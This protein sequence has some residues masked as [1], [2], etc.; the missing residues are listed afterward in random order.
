M[1]NPLIHRFLQLAELAF[2][3]MLVG[4]IM[5]IAGAVSARSVANGTGN[6]PRI[7]RPEEGKAAPLGIIRIPYGVSYKLRLE[8]IVPVW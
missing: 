3:H 7:A 2:Q 6:T 4:E 5:I 8:F 1:Q